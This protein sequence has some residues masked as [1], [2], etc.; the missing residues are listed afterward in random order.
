MSESEVV[1]VS[2]I[3]EDVKHRIVYE[4][5]KYHIT[6]DDL[7]NKYGLTWE[8]VFEIIKSAPTTYLWIKPKS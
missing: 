1:D 5:V 2:S 8:Q 4:W 7:A 3:P 6:L